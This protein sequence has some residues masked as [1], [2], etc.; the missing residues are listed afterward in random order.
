MLA[1]GGDRRRER[2]RPSREVVRVGDEL[3]DLVRRSVDRD[4]SRLATFVRD[5]GRHRPIIYIFV[6]YV[7]SYSLRVAHD[8]DLGALFGQITRRLIDAERPLLQAEDLSMWEYVVLAELARDAAPSQLVLAQRVH[9]DKTRLISLIDGLSRRGLIRRTLDPA[10]RRAH[11]I[12]L[13]ED[14]A[15]VHAR[16][17]GRVRTMESDL[18]EPFTDD[19]RTVLR[20]ILTRLAAG[21]GH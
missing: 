13:T 5:I 19:E 14:G 1:T 6:R 16:A 21:G 9:Y 20:S 3:M 2:R 4:R 18:L 12:V 7:K 17:R 10:D 15:R 11:T 8:R